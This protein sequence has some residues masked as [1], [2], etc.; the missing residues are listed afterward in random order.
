[1]FNIG[2][3]KGSSPQFKGFD[4]VSNRH[5]RLS[6]YLLT[7][8]VLTLGALITTVRARMV[9]YPSTQSLNVLIS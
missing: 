8:L 9:C 5:N 3:G 6:L 7:V 1:M 4:I 2:R